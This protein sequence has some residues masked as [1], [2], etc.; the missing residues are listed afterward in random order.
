MLVSG[1]W[2]MHHDH[3]QAIRT[4]QDLGLRISPAEVAALD[5]SVHPPFTDL[6]SVQTVIEDRGLPLVL[7]AQHCHDRDEGAFTGEVAPPM[8]ARLGVA[9][10][11]V[12][13]S[14]R[15]ELFGQSDQEVAATLR[16]VQSH[17]MTPIVCVGETE[18]EREADMTEERLASQVRLALGGLKASALASLV[19]AY[20]PIWAIGT[21]RTAT[22]E[23]AQA[24]CSFIRGLLSSLAGAE[25][26][27][28]VRIQYGG[29]VKAENAADLLR[30][31]DVDGALVG[32]A[33]VDP[34]AFAA[35]VAAAF[36]VTGAG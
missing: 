9:Y 22:P 25:T 13:H 7:G 2:K 21:G 20:E 1:N 8:L 36:S 16:A 23:D 27:A 15:R 3:L 19:V 18:D 5:V 33:S 28:A 14:E 26:A 17:G 24:A 31:P 6:R 4:V 11:I 10:V 35:I 29:S 12:G 32:G 30:Q 34:A